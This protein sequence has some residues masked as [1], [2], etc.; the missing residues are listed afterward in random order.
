MEALVQFIHSVW[1]GLGGEIGVVWFLGEVWLC[2]GEWLRSGKP[3]NPPAFLHVA[4]DEPE[5]EKMNCRERKRHPTCE[6]DIQEE[7][8]CNLSFEFSGWDGGHGVYVV[9][10]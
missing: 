1:F 4:D 5:A 7:C 8:I 2:S 6:W 3:L 10:I 9:N